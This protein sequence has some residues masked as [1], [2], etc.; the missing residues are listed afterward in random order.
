M[1]HSLWW[2]LGQF[3]IVIAGGAVLVLGVI[4]IWYGVSFVVLTTV[5]RVFPL[6][7][8]RPVADHDPA[9]GS[10]WSLAKRRWTMTLEDVGQA[11]ARLS[12][13]E[14][15]EREGTCARRGHAWTGIDTSGAQQYCGLCFQT[16]RGHSS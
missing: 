8:G 5:G 11:R 1:A 12:S 13:H 4:A 10:R 2:L 6:R 7:G 3:A 15:E 14:R 9:G 16:R